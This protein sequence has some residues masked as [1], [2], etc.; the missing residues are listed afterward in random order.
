[1]AYLRLATHPAVF[2]NP[3]SLVEAIGNIEQCSPGRTSVPRAKERRSGRSVREV[4]DDA[5]PTGDL[6]PDAHLVALM[7][8]NGVPTIGTRDRDFRRFPRIE[9]RDPFE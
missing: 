2:A 3:L 8:E 9:V 4:A 7:A 6:V 1:M 5:L